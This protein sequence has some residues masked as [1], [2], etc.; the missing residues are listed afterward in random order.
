MPAPYDRRS[1][2]LFAVTALLL[3]AMGAVSLHDTHAATQ[4]INL[5]T[6]VEIGAQKIVPGGVVAQLSVPPGT[7][8][9]EIYVEGA[10]ALVRWN[11]TTPVDSATGAMKWPAEHFRKEAND[12]RRLERLRLLCSGCTVWVN[13]S[14]RWRS[15][16][17][18]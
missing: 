11:G 5:A 2:A 3:V 10:S 17:P 16:D 12:V 14:R 7:H 15:G 13:Y 18:S 9:A 4:S 8:H 1:I 6:E